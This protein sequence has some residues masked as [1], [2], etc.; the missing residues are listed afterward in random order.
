MNRFLLLFLTVACTSAL[1]MKNENKCAPVPAMCNGSLPSSKYTTMLLPNMFNHSRFED[2]Q[3]DIE[4]WR[5][6]L[7][8]TVCNSG[9]QLRYFLCFTYAPVCVDK[10]ISPCKSL[11]ETVRDSC[12]SV[13]RQYSNYSWPSF[14]NCDQ[15]R[16]FPDDSSQMCINLN[17]LG[18]KLKSII[19]LFL[20]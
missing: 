3:R 16:R 1:A 12:D 11:C 10:L 2:V 14:F 20:L 5:P 19:S 4:I 6:L 7:S 17:M 13:M 8:S 18:K 15:R 9:D